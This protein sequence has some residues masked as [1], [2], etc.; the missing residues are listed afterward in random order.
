MPVLRSSTVYNVGPV[1][2]STEL[3][4]IPRTPNVGTCD[5]DRLPKSCSMRPHGNP[6]ISRRTTN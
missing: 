1:F 6:G 5:S 4:V 3:P 2:V